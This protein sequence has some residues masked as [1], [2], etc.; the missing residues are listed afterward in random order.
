M[1]T[2]ATLILVVVGGAFATVGGMWIARKMKGSIEIQLDNK[3]AIPGDAFKGEI[4]IAFKKAMQSNHL[5]IDII[6]Q[7]EIREFHDGKY[8][9]RYRELYRET[10]RLERSKTYHAGE[11]ISY[12]FEIDAPQMGGVTSGKVGKALDMLNTVASAF[13]QRD[14]TLNWS[15][16]ARLDAPGLDLVASIP[17]NVRMIR[18]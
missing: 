2:A 18:S 4:N 1:D 17:V 10:K 16:E 15:L 9:T 13:M 11:N 8:K 7:E 14:R 3:S 12:P 5:A 6:A